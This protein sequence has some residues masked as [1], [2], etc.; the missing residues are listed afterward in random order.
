[1]AFKKITD[2]E[3]RN[4]LVK[5]YLKL[6]DQLQDRFISERIGED[7]KSEQIKEQ[8]KAITDVLNKQSEQIIE[9][10]KLL[11]IG[12]KQQENQRLALMPP[13]EEKEITLR[14][15]PLASKYLLQ[16]INK[17]G[18][19]S[20]YGIKVTPEGFL[21]G[22]KKIDIEDN[23]IKIGRYTFPGTE[24]LY[25]II[26]KTNP[27]RS[28]LTQDDVDN[29]G[30]IMNLTNNFFHEDGTFKQASSKKYK[31]YIKQYIA[32]YYPERTRKKKASSVV[33]E[34]IQTITLP[35]NPNELI[36]RMHLLFASKTAGNTGVNDELNAIVKSLYKKKIIDKNML[37]VLSDKIKL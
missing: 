26:T 22:D 12:N 6:K 24:G 34:G 25:E 28:K 9:Q 33:G 21:L 8:S 5:E 1:M 17:P 29:Y 18:Y 20:T 19:D 37:K 4:E 13:E 10:N 35:C 36:E 23:D 15:S 30:E 31:D 11:A 27:E 16:G 14:T 3:K 7:Y 2:Y 32:Y